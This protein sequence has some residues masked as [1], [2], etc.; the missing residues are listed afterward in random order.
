MLLVLQNLFLPRFLFYSVFH[1]IVE[2]GFMDRKNLTTITGG[3]Q[4]PIFF[5]SNVLKYVKNIYHHVFKT[6]VHPE[7]KIGLV[8]SMFTL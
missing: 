1:F 7:W 5:P 8:E 4:Y 6:I 3:L 2:S